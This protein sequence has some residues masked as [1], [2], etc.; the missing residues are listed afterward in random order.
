MK[1][2]LSK[3]SELTSFNEKFILIAVIF[4]FFYCLGKSLD[5]RQWHLRSMQ[6]DQEGA[7]LFE[8]EEEWN[9]CWKEKEGK[10]SFLKKNS[11]LV[12]KI[13]LPGIFVLHKSGKRIV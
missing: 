3:Y 12:R 13:Q 6:Y 11:S 7:Y 8:G 5:S 1:I 4:F 9:S 2:V 10:N